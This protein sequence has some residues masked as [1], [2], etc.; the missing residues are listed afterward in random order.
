[1]LLRENADISLVGMD[2][3]LKQLEENLDV[4]PPTFLKEVAGDKMSA[5]RNFTL[6][7][8]RKADVTYH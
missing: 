1:M 8:C 4:P 2:I 6:Q 5:R 3:D 7:A